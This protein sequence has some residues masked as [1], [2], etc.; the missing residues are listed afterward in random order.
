MDFTK[1]VCLT[2]INAYESKLIE[3]CSFYKYSGLFTFNLLGYH[4]H[5]MICVT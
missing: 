1:D 5:Y 3:E 4:P 2:K